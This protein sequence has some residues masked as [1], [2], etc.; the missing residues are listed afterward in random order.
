MPVR[1]PVRITAT[2]QQYN[3]CK[4]I[5]L[6]FGKSEQNSTTIYFKQYQSCMPR[7][8]PVRITATYHQYNQYN[9]NKFIPFVYGRYVLRFKFCLRTYSTTNTT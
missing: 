9:L 2:Y 4:L 3:L 8:T 1:T 5:P 6:V 7:C